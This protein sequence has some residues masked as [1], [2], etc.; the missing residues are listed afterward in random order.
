MVCEY[1]DY[2]EC[3]EATGICVAKDGMCVVD[4]DCAASEE[5]NTATHECVAAPIIRNGGFEKWTD[6]KPDS[7]YG[8]KTNI[9]SLSQ[10][11]AEANVHGGSSS[12]KLVPGQSKTRFS[13]A[14]YTLPAGTYNCEYYAKG[15][16][17]TGL[18][19]YYPGQGGNGDFS[20]VS[21][22]TVEENSWTQITYSFTLGSDVSDF[23]L[24]VYAKNADNTYVIVDDLSCT[25]E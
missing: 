3:S 16:T 13:T 21:Y 24:V 10:E 7:W 17:Q 14:A 12:V 11:T 19:V 4:S 6:S 9:A 20:S 22:K 15:T 5:C 23:Q 2:Q 18:A 25:K 8:S 1:P